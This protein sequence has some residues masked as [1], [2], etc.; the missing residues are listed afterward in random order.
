VNT[1][2]EAAR[3]VTKRLKSQYMADLAKNRLGE[4]K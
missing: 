4:Q 2:E 3:L 1:P